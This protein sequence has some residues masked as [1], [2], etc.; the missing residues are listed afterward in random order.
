MEMIQG[1]DILIFE[2]GTELKVDLIEYYH[3]DGHA[4]QYVE[5]TSGKGE[6]HTF[7]DNGLTDSETGLKGRIIK[8]LRP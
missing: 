6:T 7:I 2:D 3:H 4:I 1:G 5:G 8:C